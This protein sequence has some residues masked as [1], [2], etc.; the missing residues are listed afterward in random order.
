MGEPEMLKV[1]MM[2]M[3]KN[4]HDDEIERFR[5]NDFQLENSA[6]SASQRND[7]QNLETGIKRKV[8]SSAATGGANKR[9]KPNSESQQM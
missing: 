1:L 7:E 2:H 9:L 8:N 6:F 4:Y 5:L 3:S